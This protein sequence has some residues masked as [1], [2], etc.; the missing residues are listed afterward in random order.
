VMEKRAKFSFIYY[1]VIL[2]CIFVF[3]SLFFSGPEIKEIPYSEFKDLLAANKIETVV[4]TQNKITGVLKPSESKKKEPAPAL[5]EQKKI[6]AAPTPPEAKKE[7]PAQ[8]NPEQKKVDAAPPVPEAQQHTQAKPETRQT[9]KIGWPKF[10]YPPWRLKLKQ[11]EE[12]NEDKI[13]RSFTVVPLKDDKLLEDLQSDGVDYRG[14]ITSDWFQNIILNW[15]IPFAFLFVIWGFL[16]RRMGGGAN[17]L[18]VGKSK[19]KIYAQDTTN[20]VTF[21]DVAGIDEAVEEVQEVVDF[22]QNTSC[23]SCC[24]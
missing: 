13:K 10:L 16:F 14:K 11:I 5:A 7:T 3:E 19:A 17:V 15:I 2:L 12:Q 21:K 8:A 1:I 6:T 9:Q 24:R 20:K 23:Q 22:L 4:I 18:N